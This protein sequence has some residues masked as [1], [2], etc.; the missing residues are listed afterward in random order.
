MHACIH[1]CTSVS[2]TTMSTPTSKS[3]PGNGSSKSSRARHLTS[4]GIP[5]AE[6]L[7]S[8]HSLYDSYVFRFRSGGWILLCCLA[9][10]VPLK[11]WIEQQTTTPHL[12]VMFQS[13][14]TNN[15]SSRSSSSSS[16]PLSSSGNQSV[17]P[18]RTIST[19]IQ[20]PSRS[21]Q[22]LFLSTTDQP[23]V[24]SWDDDDDDKD[25]AV[26][27]PVCSPID[28]IGPLTRRAGT[29]LG[30][31]SSI[32]EPGFLTGS[33]LLPTTDGPAV[34]EFQITGFTH[35]FVHGMEQLYRCLC[36]WLA[37]NERSA[38][39]IYNQK[40][41]GV[42]VFYAGFL[43]ALER[44]FHVAIV[45]DYTG[46]SVRQ[47]LSIR[48]GHAPFGMLGP[49]YAQTMSRRIFQFYNLS[50][51]LDDAALR[52]EQRFPRIGILNRNGDIERTLLNADELHRRLLNESSKRH[53]FTVHPI[54]YFETS[55]FLAQVKYYGSVDI[56]ISPHGAQLSA[57]PFLP[58][59]GS[60]LELYPKGYWLPDYFGTLASGA[61][62]A[63]A[64]FH[65]CA[66]PNYFGGRKTRSA[67]L[68]PPLDPLVDGVWELVTDWK[69]CVASY[70]ESSLTI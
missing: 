63:H 65:L 31:Y 17:V 3:D 54:Q 29:T 2:A 69:Q 45:P 51:V 36:F 62:I 70:N 28:E 49:A 1:A 38:V 30:Y 44:V 26:V 33:G 32:Y 35:H 23:S 14:E 66:G 64:Y 67:K 24:R 68:C 10:L 6:S 37:Q 11:L 13:N 59:C 55:S 53:A 16:N 42:K 40:F 8:H 56:V 61:G 9:L 60:V 57:M 58:P 12:S 46:P 21:N 15:S 34:C 39:L 18:N 22:T 5:P 20:R 4:P 43:E 52:R 48:D 25:T 47:D 50:K 7:S 19:S 27:E 41:A